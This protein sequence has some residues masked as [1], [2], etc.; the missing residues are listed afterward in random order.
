[1][2]RKRHCVAVDTP[3]A[4]DASMG[5]DSCPHCAILLT[6]AG[7]KV[8]LCND[9]VIKATVF[10]FLRRPVTANRKQHVLHYNITKMVCEK[11]LSWIQSLLGVSTFQSDTSKR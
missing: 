5:R 4:S 3:G 9:V 7:R 10:T 1:M 8:A 2:L 6:L 11:H